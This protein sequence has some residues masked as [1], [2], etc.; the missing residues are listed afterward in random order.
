MAPQW[1]VSSDLSRHPLAVK[2]SQFLFKSGFDKIE[3][4]LIL[5]ILALEYTPF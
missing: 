1:P 5:L 3:K 4:L 2:I